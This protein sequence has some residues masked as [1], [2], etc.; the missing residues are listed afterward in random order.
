MTISQTLLRSAI[1]VYRKA[2]SPFLPAACR[3]HPTCSIYA[4][5]AVARHGAAKGTLLSLKRL[6]RCHPFHPG[7]CDPVPGSERAGEHVNERVT[8]PAGTAG[9]TTTE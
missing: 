8:I 9:K 7:G 6:A 5:E 4:S 2:V 3:F 1:A